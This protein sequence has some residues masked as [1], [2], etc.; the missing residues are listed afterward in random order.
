[1]NNFTLPPAGPATRLDRLRIWTQQ[2]KWR[3]VLVVGGLFLI[4]WTLLFGSWI[5]V[6]LLRGSTDRDA[7]AVALNIVLVLFLGTVLLTMTQ[8]ACYRWFWH[9]DRQRMQGLLKPGDET[10]QFGGQATDPPPVIAWPWMLRLRHTVFYL[11]GMAT[12]FYTFLPYA[13]QLAIGQ[14]LFRYS[15]GRASA[16]N[17]AMLLFGFLPMIVLGMLSMA[18]L[19]R[20]MRRRD[21]GVLS[22]GEQLIL[23]AEMNWLF[24][25][26][27]AFG[28]TMLLCHFFG[29]M[30]MRYL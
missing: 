24:A 13:N 23:A 30:V 6:A 11:I 12:I 5:G 22:E 18:L 1:M 20:Q 29:S 28:M 14:F 19:S 7:G 8:R 17:L 9:H 16:G 2:S 3:Q 26:A 4:G 27:T 10:F 21:A 15:A 25:F